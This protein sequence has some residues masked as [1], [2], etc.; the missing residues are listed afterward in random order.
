[1]KIAIASGK[2]GTGKTMISTNLFRAAEKEGIDV[3]LID[4]DAEEPNVTEFISGTLTSTKPVT[5]NIPVIDTNKCVFCGKCHEYCS[6]HAIVYLP[7]VKFIKVVEELCHS[8]GAC[9]EACKFGAIDEKEKPLGMITTSSFN[10][11]ANIIEGRANVGIYSPVPVIKESIRCNTE[12]D[13]TILDSPPG[14]S[15]PFI[16]TVSRADFVVLV[17]EPTPFGLNDLKLSVETLRTL[18]KPFGV[19]INRAGL[20]NREV[21][22]W[23]EENKI[24]L[25]AEIKFSR[26]IAHIYSQGKM[27][28]DEIPAFHNIFIDL[29]K[30]ICNLC[31]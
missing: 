7:P 13:L 22:S 5:C 17:T 15:C 26:E 20:G 25:L 11:H 29:Y 3:T 8:C 21:Y 10:N 31:K 2:G 30:S 6:Y 18:N 23:L 1:M 16:T 14:I 12:S 28:V 19:I 27:L 24:P 4:C 9:I